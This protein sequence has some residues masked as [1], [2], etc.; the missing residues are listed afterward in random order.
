MAG[1]R[2]RDLANMI[3]VSHTLICHYEAGRQKIPEHRLK[4]LCRVFKVS[5]DDLK[6]FQEGRKSLPINYKDECFLLINRMNT[7]QLQAVY[8]MLSGMVG[9]M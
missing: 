6:D 7:T 9:N 3:E 2:V 8:G 1:L 4:Q 5:T